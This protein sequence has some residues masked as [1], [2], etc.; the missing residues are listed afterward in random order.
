M[1]VADRAIG[2]YV[3]GRYEVYNKTLCW[4]QIKVCNS[5]QNSFPALKR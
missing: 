3:E 4:W 1:L 5:T 2:C